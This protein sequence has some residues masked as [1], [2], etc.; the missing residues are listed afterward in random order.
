M[1]LWDINRNE[2]KNRRLKKER[3]IWFE[4]IEIACNNDKILE[5]KGNLNYPNQKMLIV[6][7]NNYA[8]VIPFI[9]SEKECFLK[10]I[11]KSRKYT[12]FYNLK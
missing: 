7:I 8:Y 2:E 11:Y 12:K 5:I 3:S 6:N 9:Q 10:T 1:F 4:D